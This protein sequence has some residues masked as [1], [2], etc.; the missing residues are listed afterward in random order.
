[1]PV[2]IITIIMMYVIIFVWSNH[3]LGKMEISKKIIF[4]IVV[5]L[6]VYLLTNLTFNISKNGITYPKGLELESIK[7]TLV[8]V[9]TGLNLIF[10]LPYL[11]K[12][13]EKLY[14]E[15]IEIKEFGKSIIISLIVLIILLIFEIGYMK[16][17][18]E[19]IVKIFEN[20][21]H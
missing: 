4:M 3:N 11:S 6:L 5:A 15:N 17:T 10:I 16:D 18:Q 19:M 9:F 2:I 12:R 20:K 14:Q 13:F 21:K 1:M 7:N 8:W